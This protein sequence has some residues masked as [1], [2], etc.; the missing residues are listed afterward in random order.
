MSKLS[1]I[2]ASVLGIP[3]EKV[4]TSL[5]PETEPAWDSLN[6]IILITEIE[7]AFDMRF[8]YDEAMA[9]KNYGDAIKLIESKGKDPHA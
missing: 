4:T 3:E 5:S 9:V 1:N 8:G 6:S 7:S 2:F